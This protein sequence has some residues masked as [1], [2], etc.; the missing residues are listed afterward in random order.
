[1]GLKAENFANSNGN[2]ANVEFVVKEDGKLTITKRDVTLTSADAEK[3]YDG[4][5]LTND[6]VTVSGDGF[7]KNDGATYDVTGTITNVGTK[8]NTF[9]Y[10]LNEGTRQTTTTSHRRKVA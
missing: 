1:M 7:V 10:T 3:V 8:P 2:F 4:T 9:T 5:A 6:T